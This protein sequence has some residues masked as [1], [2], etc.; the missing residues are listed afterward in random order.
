MLDI[1][2]Y[3]SSLGEQIRQ[4]I[5]GAFPVKSVKNFVSSQNYGFLRSVQ[6]G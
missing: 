4:I 2:G 3:C 6:G 5:K 1:Q